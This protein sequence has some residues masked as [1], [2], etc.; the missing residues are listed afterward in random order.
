MLSLAA[1][2]NFNMHIVNGVVRRLPDADI[3]RVQDAGLAGASDP[4]V[5]EWAAEEDRVLLTHDVNTIT[6][7]AYQRIEQGSPM[8]GVFEISLRVPVSLAIEQ[9]VLIAQ[10]S[11]KGEWEG[12]VNYLPLR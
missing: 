7:F 4:M 10:C 3:V 1:D 5:L 8:P 11:L 6:A 9:I 2:E 12:Q